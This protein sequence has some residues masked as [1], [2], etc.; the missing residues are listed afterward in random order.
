MFGSLRERLERRQ[1]LQRR[2]DGLVE[3]VASSGIKDTNV[4]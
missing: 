1:C 2:I 3:G 4:N